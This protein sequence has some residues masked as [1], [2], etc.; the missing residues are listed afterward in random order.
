MSDTNVTV[1]NTVELTVE[2]FNAIKYCANCETPQHCG[3]AETYAVRDFD[4]KLT[5]QMAECIH[6]QCEDC[7]G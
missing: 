1:T 6:C 5:G 7:V 2:E 3:H 4:G